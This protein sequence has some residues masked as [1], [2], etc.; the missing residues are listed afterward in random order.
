MGISRS[1]EAPLF[2]SDG[3]E[4]RVLRP[5]LLGRISGRASGHSGRRTSFAGRRYD[6]F[7]EFPGHERVGVVQDAR[8]GVFCVVVAVVVVVVLNARL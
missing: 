5:R 3:A 2:R 6:V 4:A 1:L 8:F 7:P